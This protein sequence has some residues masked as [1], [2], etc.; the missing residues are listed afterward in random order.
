MKVMSFR[1]DRRAAEE[2]IRILEQELERLHA[3]EQRADALATDLGETRAALEAARR[4]VAA[5]KEA[6]RPSR[7]RRLIGLGVVGATVALGWAYHTYPIA[8]APAATWID[9]GVTKIPI[10]DPPPATTPDPA[11]GA[12]PP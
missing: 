12:E 10:P 7:R 2:R 11:S 4:R 6:R 9:E 8:G 1:D 3:A 5:L